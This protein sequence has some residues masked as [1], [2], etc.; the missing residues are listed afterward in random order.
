MLVGDHGVY[1]MNPSEKPPRT[2]VYANGCNP[3]TDENWWMEK[4]ATFGGD[5]GA[6]QFPLNEVQ[7]WIDANTGS[8]ISIE[9]TAE[10]I[11]FLAPVT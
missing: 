6:E 8:Q 7:E 4:S 9:I 10:Q 11:A 5:D 1:F 3:N 2:C